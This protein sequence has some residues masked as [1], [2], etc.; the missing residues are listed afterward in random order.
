[1][2]NIAR[3]AFLGNKLFFHQSVYQNLTS[4]LGSNLDV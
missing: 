3:Y 4:D 1:M 2:N